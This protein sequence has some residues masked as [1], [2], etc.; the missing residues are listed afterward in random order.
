MCVCVCVGN[1]DVWGV[2]RYKCYCPLNCVILECKLVMNGKFH[3][4]VVALHFV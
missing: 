2:N 4:K 1:C 3:L